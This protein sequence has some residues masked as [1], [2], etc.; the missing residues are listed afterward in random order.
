MSGSQQLRALVALRW[1]MVRS[2]AARAGLL[3]LASL[4]PLAVLLGVAGAQLAPESARLDAAVA[5]PTIYLGFFVLSIV[6]PLTA[7]GGNELYPQE[8][9][10]AYPITPATHFLTGLAVLPINLA[11]VS[12]LVVLTAATSF[13]LPRRP[14]AFLAVPTVLAYVVLAA[15]AGQLGSW[16]VAGVR[17]TRNGRA[18]LWAL[19]GGTVVTFLALV[20]TGGLDEVVDATPTV[21][22][23]VAAGSGAQRDWGTWAPRTLILAALAVAALYAGRRACDW[24]LRRPGDAGTSREG[25]PV[26]VRRPRRSAFREL[27]AVDRASVWRSAS[28]RRG[29]LVLGLLPGLVTFVLGVQWS[30]LLLLPGLVASGAALLFGVNAFCLDGGGAVWLATLPHRPSMALWSKAWVLTETALVCVLLSVGAALLRVRGAPTTAEAAALAAAVV[31]T[32][33]SVV[34]TSLRLSVERPHRADLRGR[35]DTPA[36]PG[37]MAVYSARMAAQ[38]TFTGLFVA[39]A[40]A[41]GWWPMPVLV[42]SVVALLGLRSIAVAAREWRE[43]GRRA[44]VAVTV[45]AG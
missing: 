17:Q 19:A 40:A 8:Q 9:L 13:F 44:Y 37:T 10:V 38:T 7:G 30:T 5:A 22:V 34:G 26:R 12:Q 16:L 18:A 41:T 24:A 25:R 15:A 11:W 45:G 4:I 33:T 27:L 2:P 39:G 32:V 14:A 23:V 42:A 31:A 43:P 28:L 20:K 3:A 36:P 29:A 21:E 1:R 6:S 35:R